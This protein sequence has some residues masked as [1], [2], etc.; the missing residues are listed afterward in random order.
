MVLPPGS[1]WSTGQLIGLGYRKTLGEAV[2]PPSRV[3]QGPSLLQLS[4]DTKPGPGVNTPI[5]SFPPPL[6]VFAQSGNWGLNGELGSTLVVLS[7]V[8]RR[9]THLSLLPS[10]LSFIAVLGTTSCSDCRMPYTCPHR[11]KLVE[12]RD[13]HSSTLFLGKSIS[14]SK[15]VDSVRA[16]WVVR[17]ALAY[18]F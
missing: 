4:N 15:G 3:Y 12:H 1:I 6:D 2:C 13:C 11:L 5:T 7:E 18:S 10:L 9:R 17:S 8:H 14:H 16:E